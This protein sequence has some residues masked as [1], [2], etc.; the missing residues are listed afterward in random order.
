[1]MKSR[2]IAILITILTVMILVAG[3]SGGAAS[4]TVPTDD[5]T[6]LDGATL[7]QERCSVCHSL[8]TSPGRTVDQWKAVVRNMVARGA[9]LNEQEQSFLIDYL[10]TNYGK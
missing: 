6:A 10:A 1:M 2:T 3:C 9:E 8:P 4:T 7:F 5:P